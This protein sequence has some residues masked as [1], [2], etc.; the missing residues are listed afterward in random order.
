MHRMERTWIS[1]LVQALLVGFLPLPAGFA[2]RAYLLQKMEDSDL[3]P[4]PLVIGLW[5]DDAV[6]RCAGPG[7]SLLTA[8]GISQQHRVLV[9][10][11]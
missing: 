1:V 7:P 5:V 8:P 6:E 3:T 11:M 9:I 2:V 10:A 4:A